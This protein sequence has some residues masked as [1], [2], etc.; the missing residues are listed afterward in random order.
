MEIWKDCK[1]YEGKYQVSNLGRVWNVNRQHYLYGSFDK[2][3]YIYVHLTAKNGKRKKERVHRL[4]ALA[5]LPN[6]TN[7]P[8]VH[9]KDENKQNNCVSNLAWA[10]VRE[11]TIYSKGKAIRCIELDRIFD[12]SQTAMKELNIDGSDIRKCCKGQKKTA[13]GYHWEYYNGEH[14]SET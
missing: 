2:D 14:K 5:F 8:V 6:P 13:G 3:G 11:N 1:G 12:C 7:L 4:V 10:S 9:H